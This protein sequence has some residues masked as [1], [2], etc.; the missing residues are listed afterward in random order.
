M[1]PVGYKERVVL[2]ASQPSCFGAGLSCDVLK[3]L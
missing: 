2:V 3:D 1:S